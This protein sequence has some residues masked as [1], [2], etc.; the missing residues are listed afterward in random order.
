MTQPTDALLAGLA[1]HTAE[2]RDAALA[3]RETYRFSRWQKTTIALGVLLLAAN[4]VMLVVLIGMASTNRANGQAIRSCTTPAGE[5]YQ[6]GQKN[7]AQAVAAIVGQVN[8][9]TDRVFIASLQCSG[10]PMHTEAF[11]RCLQAKGVG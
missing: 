3:L 4:A 7:T 11:T 1:V 9:H 10:H 8:A 6:Q 2:L 5:C